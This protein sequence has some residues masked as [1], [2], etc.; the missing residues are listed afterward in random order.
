MTKEQ[1]CAQRS[2]R[3]ETAVRLGTPDRVPFVPMISSFYALGYGA[4][5]Y[6]LM[7]DPRFAREGLRKFLLEYEPDEGCPAGLYNMA[8]LEALQP[9]F[10]RWPGPEFGIPAGNSFQHLDTE[11][12]LEEEYEDFITDPTHTIL[13]KILP[14]KHKKLQ[15]LAKLDFHDI[16]DKNLIE[17]FAVL[18]DPDV[19]TALQAMTEAGKACL[20]ARARQGEVMAVM[21][22][23]GF[24]PFCQG[25]LVIPFDTFA[26]SARG[27]INMTMDLITC[28]ED[29]ERAVGALT[30]LMLRKQVSAAAARGAKRLMIPM[31]CGVDSFMSP[32]NYERFYW[33]NL[34]ECLEMI[35][36]YGMTPICFCEGS[37]NTRLEALCDVPKGKVIYFFENVD[38]QKAKD[39]VG[40]VA[41]IGGSVPS[42]MLAFGKPEEVEY[43]TRRQIDIL[44]PGGGYIMSCSAMLDNADHRN[45]AVW[46]ET[47]LKYGVY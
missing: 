13:T 41:C 12:L 25:G 8:S 34:K 47:T 1:L 10:L 35:I 36:S 20:Q 27:I 22:E 7:R 4:S 11:C 9:T 2:A 14:R 19:Q 32:A 39:T 31:H 38:L 29:V 40:K 18:C 21:G 42:S 6:D 24:A 46:K 17:S 30:K 5:Y 37:Y 26:D 23:E 3:V 43:E 33:K 45:M 28:P 44:A 16:Y 15:G